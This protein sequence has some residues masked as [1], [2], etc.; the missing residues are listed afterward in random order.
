MAKVRRLAKESG[1]RVWDYSH[2]AIADWAADG[3]S[4]THVPIGYT[5]NLTRIPPSSPQDIDVLFVG[6]MTP[7]R[8]AIIDDLRTVGL[9]V[10]SSASC[11]GGARDQLISRAKVI[12]NVHHDGRDRFEIVRCSYL[13]ANSACIVSEL[14]SD[15][16]EYQD[17]VLTRVPYRLLVD[18][19][20]SLCGAGSESR[21]RS[22]ESLKN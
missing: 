9:R 4:A 7:R 3:I 13:M 8:M 17:L 18:T 10:F 20:I 5:P 15:D 1:C 12:L 19:C 11:Y 21:K 2:R 14:S 6:W 22:G 16:D